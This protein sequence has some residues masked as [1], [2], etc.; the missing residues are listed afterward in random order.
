MKKYFLSI[1][2]FTLNCLA[3]FGQS[4]LQEYIKTGLENN[5]QFLKAR[6]ATQ[7]AYQEN[8]VAKSYFL[9]DVA[10]QASY[11]LAEGGRTIDF[12]IGDLFNPAYA[13]LNQLTGTEQFPTDI[14]NV[15][16]QFL[17]NDFHET[18]IR[19]AQPIFNT[20]IYFG[21]KASQ[22]NISVNQAKENSYRNQLIFEIT[23]AYY[24]HLQV[25]AQQQILDS[26]KFVLKQLVQV[27]EKLIKNDV[28]TKDV[29][30]NAQAQ[31]DNLDAQ[32]ATVQKNVNTSRI[33]FNYLL[34]RDLT[35]PILVNDPTDEEISINE[36]SLDLAQN[37]AISNRSDLLVVKGGIEAQQFL[38][39]KE[40]AYLLPD[41]SVGAEFGYQGFG[42]TFDE[43]QDF[44]LLSFNLNWSIFQGGRN[45][46][47]VQL[48]NLQKEQVSAD[49]QNLK[50]QIQ[51]EV[52][53]AFYEWEETLK[54]YKARLSELKNAKENFNIV[55]GQY[56]TNQAL[57]VQFNQARNDLT[58]AQLATAIAKYNIAISKANL[59]RTTQ[60]NF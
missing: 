8:N 60:T 56:E 9:P 35:E 46:S 54:I 57:L 40:K 17:P 5:Q 33:F 24:N 59:Q 51:L 30:Y 27:N 29:L 23:K 47:Q 10:F 14:S 20:D 42:Y 7:I 4:V 41:V 38:I 12:P 48:A 2:F 3:S 45:K 52:A 11:L 53:N 55:K 15:N 34:N 26:T 1:L 13:A 31:L 21:Y 6:L 50:Q 16:E 18:K 49:Y 37:E 32:I 25:L 43:N 28:A 44:Y 36:W 58:T 19:I 22:A 39:R